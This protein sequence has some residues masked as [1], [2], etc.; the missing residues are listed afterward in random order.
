MIGITGGSC[1]GKTELAA[2][3]CRHLAPRSVEVFALDAYYLDRPET[4]TEEAARGNFD[5]PEAL[6]HLL[7]FSQLEAL[8]LGTTVEMPVY[9]FR[10]HRR[11]AVSRRVWPVEYILVEGLHAL[12]WERLRK[13]M[14]LRVYLDAEEQLRLNRRLERDTRLRGRTVES[15]REQWARNVRP[16]HERFVSQARGHADLVLDGA[17]PIDKLA[18]RLARAIV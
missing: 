13:L 4:N 10:T 17:E 1:S 12:H 5:H 15:I 16:M 14:W 8:A 3:L 18:A 6:D 9:D 7:L 11:C 2:C